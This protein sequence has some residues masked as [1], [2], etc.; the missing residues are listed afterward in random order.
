MVC[1]YVM[2]GQAGNLDEDTK[3]RLPFHFLHRRSRWR[4]AVVHDAVPAAIVAEYDS[5]G[6]SD[7]GDVI[8]QNDGA[9]IDIPEMVDKPLAHI[10]SD[11]S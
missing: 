2:R 10:P 9:L 3:D 4:K 8:F 6:Y 5:S 11:A 1:R 7:S